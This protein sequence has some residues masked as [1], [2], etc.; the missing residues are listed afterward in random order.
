MNKEGVG[1]ADLTEFVIY[2]SF[3]A[4]I[5]RRL[6]G[7]VFNVDDIYAHDILE[8]QAGVVQAGVL[9]DK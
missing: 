2:L 4:T 5:R 3:V 1:T 6:S 7:K 8:N 9:T